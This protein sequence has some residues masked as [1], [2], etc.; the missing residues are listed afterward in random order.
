MNAPGQSAI[1]NFIS[2]FSDLLRLPRAFWI[3][4]FAFV[5]D[6]MAYFGVLTLMTTFLSADLGWGDRNAGV[7]VSIF[8]ML[9]TLFMLGIASY[10]E[11]FGLRRAILLGLGTAVAGRVVYSLAP[12]LHGPIVVVAVIGSL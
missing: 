3:V 7:T 2:S 9:V 8:T 5:I 1:R 10:V 6:S 4:I 12:G 11:R